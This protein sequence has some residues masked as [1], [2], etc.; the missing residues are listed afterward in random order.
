MGVPARL[1]VGYGRGDLESRS[2][3]TDPTPI[4]HPPPARRRA[5]P[6][7]AAGESQSGGELR[8]RRR[9]RR[10]ERHRRPAVDASDAALRGRDGSG[11]G[12]GSRSGLRSHPAPWHGGGAARP[13]LHG[14]GGGEG[15]R[16]GPALLLSVPG[17]G[18]GLADRAHADPA[19]GPGRALRG[20]GLLVFELPRRLLQRLPGHGADRRHRRGAAPR[21]LHLRVRGRRLRLGPRP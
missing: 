4:R 21:R 16:S 5:G 11:L 13:R 7:A 20:G 19:R 14:Q 18:R 6:G 10:P 2:H 3:E 15:P 8:P 1:R 9:Q 12:A 17:P